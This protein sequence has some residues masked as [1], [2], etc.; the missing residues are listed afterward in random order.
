MRTL[1]IKFGGT[2]VGSAAAFR[3]AA[4]I[5]LE[6]AAAW[7]RVVVV[8]SAMAGVTDG[9]IK[10][11][12]QINETPDKRELDA[13]L[14]TGEQTTAALLAMMLGSMGFPAATAQFRIASPVPRWDEA[15]RTGSRAC[16]GTKFNLLE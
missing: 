11:A 16:A 13:L 14:A 12:K 2:S 9:L 8:V 6:Q 15:V 3:Q 4:D 7:E 5:V 10:L 1:V